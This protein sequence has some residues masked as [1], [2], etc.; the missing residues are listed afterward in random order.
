MPRKTISHGHLYI[1][2]VNR[3]SHTGQI[4]LTV[5]H[6]EDVFE[7]KDGDEFITFV[8]PEPLFDEEG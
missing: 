2:R 5:G 6:D 8:T 1:A 7:V 4:N 3:D